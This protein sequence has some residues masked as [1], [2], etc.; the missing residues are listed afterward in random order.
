[1]R[2]ENKRNCYTATGIFA[3]F[4]HWTVLIHFV[5][6]K[7]IGPYGSTVGFATVNRFVHELTGVHMYLYHVTDWL[8]IIPI[9]CMV[10]F[11]ILG[12]QQ[13][14][15]R[16]HILKVDYSILILGVFFFIVISLYILFEFYIVNY[17]P[18]LINGVLEASYPSSTTMLVMTVMPTTNIQF[19]SRIKCTVTRQLTAFVINAYVVFMVFGRLIAGVHW[20]SDIVGGALFSI[21]LVRAYREVVGLVDK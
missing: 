10:G 14:I 8:G 17:R 7:A 13:W 12:L 11:T 6:V 16:K 1:M 4:L 18:V 21:A 5:D 9:C 15:N 2:N 19:N 20:F 3:A